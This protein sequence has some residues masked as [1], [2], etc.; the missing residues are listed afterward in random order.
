MV[1]TVKNTRFTS[2]LP[3]IFQEGNLL[4]FYNKLQQ[5]KEKYNNSKKKYLLKEACKK[6]KFNYNTV[7]MGLNGNSEYLKNYHPGYK[8]YRNEAGFNRDQ[9]DYGLVQDILLD[10]TRDEIVEFNRIVNELRIK[11]IAT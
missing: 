8:R 5:L 2:K 3:M 4:K 1:Q 11:N 7:Y 10:S 9:E 6:L